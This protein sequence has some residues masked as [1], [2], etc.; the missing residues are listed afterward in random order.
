MLLKFLLLQG[1]CIKNPKIIQHLNKTASDKCLLYK[2]PLPGFV[3]K[4]N[5][6]ILLQV[7]WPRISLSI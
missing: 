2:S 6:L 1:D 7:L 4:I 3:S 5:A